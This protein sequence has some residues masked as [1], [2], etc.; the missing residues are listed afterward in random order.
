M[1]Y[2]EKLYDKGKLGRGARAARR[3]NAALRLLRDYEYSGFV[4]SI[5]CPLA[6][7][8]CRAK[9]VKN[10]DAVDR[11]EAVD[12]YLAGVRAC[13]PECFSVVEHFVLND[14]T[15]AAYLR[16]NLLPDGG[17]VAAMIYGLLGRGLDLISETYEKG[18]ENG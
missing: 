10:D 3:L 6:Y 18:K 17:R 8:D 5:R 9:G 2:I 12:R 16:R 4:P 1:L 13:G 7:A 14:S 15:M 11:I